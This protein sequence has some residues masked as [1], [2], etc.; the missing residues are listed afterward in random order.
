MAGAVVVLEVDDDD[1]DDD[2][3]VVAINTVT[4]VIDW[5]VSPAPRVTTVLVATIPELVTVQTAGDN[6]QSYSSPT[7]GP[8]LRCMVF[9]PYV[10]VRLLKSPSHE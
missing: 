1:D 8:R 9:G 2:V 4:G 5:D 6:W 10:R 7:E 3:E